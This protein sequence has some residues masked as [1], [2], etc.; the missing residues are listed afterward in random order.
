MMAWI[1][2][3]L[4]LNVHL[5]F[6]FPWDQKRCFPGVYGISGLV[7]YNGISADFLMVIEN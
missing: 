5:G 4:H 2:M 7:D 1:G 3:G 6:Q